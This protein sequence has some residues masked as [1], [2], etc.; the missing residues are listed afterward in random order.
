MISFILF[1]SFFGFI[2]LLAF[3]CE[4]YCGPRLLVKKDLASFVYSELVHVSDVLCSPNLSRSYSTIFDKFRERFN[5]VE[6]FLLSDKF[7]LSYLT[8]NYSDLF[9][10]N[11]WCIGLRNI[12]IFNRMGDG[13]KAGY[14]ARCLWGFDTK[15][16]IFEMIENNDSLCVFNISVNDDDTIIHIRVKDYYNYE[17]NS[18]KDF[19]IYYAERRAFELYK[20]TLTCEH[21]WVPIAGVYAKCSKCEKVTSEYAELL[22][23]SFCGETI[24]DSFTVLPSDSGKPSIQEIYKY[25]EKYKLLC[26]DCIS[27]NEFYTPSEKTVLKY[28]E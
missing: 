6:K 2:I 7:L 9:L 22:N 24:K 1:V 10:V 8:R 18:K 19:E 15:V 20:K 14:T 11:G 12:R 23:C 26:S 4:S 13:F 16:S 5:F 28:E 3:L 25:P 27:T 21:N 17:K